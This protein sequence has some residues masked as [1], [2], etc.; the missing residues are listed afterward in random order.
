MTTLT[1]GIFTRTRRG[2]GGS[3]G[4]YRDY[5]VR[6][7]S[8]ANAVEIVHAEEA[9][10][11]ADGMRLASPLVAPP[12]VKSGGAQMFQQLLARGSRAVEALRIV[13]REQNQ[14]GAARLDGLH[15][16]FQD[17]HLSAFDV[18]FDDVRCRPRSKEGA[19]GE[20]L[21]L[22]LPAPQTAIDRAAAPR[23]EGIH[24]KGRRPD[25][26]GDGLVDGNHAVAEPVLFHVPAEI[27]IP[28]G[29][30]FKS[31]D[32]AL[33]APLPGGE[34]RVGPEGGATGFEPATSSVTGRCPKPR[35]TTPPRS[36]E[37]PKTRETTWGADHSRQKALY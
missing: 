11:R 21:A 17:A 35:Y 19:Q 32:S 9:H 22:D 25:A 28:S 16:P 1:A 3:A 13:F 29:G 24:V 12:H 6:P 36:A 14:S 26:I 34:P 27:R 31:I 2:R 30:G 37:T 15:H 18:Q 7:P 8:P 5:P 10:P 23:V 20:C 4:D 33:R